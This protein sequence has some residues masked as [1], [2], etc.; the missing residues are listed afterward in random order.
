M[1]IQEVNRSD[2]ERVWVSATNVEGATMTAHYSAFLMTMQKNTASVGTNE[3]TLRGNAST[4]DKSVGSF[5]GLANE[6]I[7]NNDV[8]QVQVYGYHESANILRIVGSVT[9]R[10]GDPL[11]PGANGSTGLSS[12]GATQGYLGPVV[13]LDTVTATL[14]S[15][16]TPATNYADHVFIRGM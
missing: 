9:V 16:G 1:Q 11:G 14:H 7:P 2:A 3:V 15:L 13:A 4:D 6:D 8:G 10:A 5:I 12:V